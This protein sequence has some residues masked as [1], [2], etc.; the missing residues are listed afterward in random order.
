MSQK[1]SLGDENLPAAK[2]LA[3]EVLTNATLT[4]SDA[5]VHDVGTVGVFQ[6]QALNTPD[7]IRI[8][9]LR[10]AASIHAPLIGRIES[11][12][13]KDLDNDL[14]VVQ[15]YIAVSYAWG[16]DP[17]YTHKVICDGEILPITLNVDRMLRDLRRFDCERRLWIDALCLNQADPDEKAK[18]I[19]RM[20]SIYEKATK[21]YIWLDPTKIIK[22]TEPCDHIF[23]LLRSV[24]AGNVKVDAEQAA[25]IQAFLEKRW[26]RR[27]WVIQES[28]AHPNTK[29]FCDGRSKHWDEVIAALM[30]V[31]AEAASAFDKRAVSLIKAIDMIWEPRGSILDLLAEFHDFDCSDPGIG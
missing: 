31:L 11:K 9:V 10:P 25:A 23:D 15:D 19:P 6:Y 22:D 14:W 2:R 27:R 24:R 18:Q 30:T 21:V 28:T 26:F 13:C 16:K 20:R 12:P 4:S 29:V 17:T 1:R 7:F 8:F 3:G 5:D